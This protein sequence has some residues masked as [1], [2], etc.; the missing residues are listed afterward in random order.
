MANGKIVFSNKRGTMTMVPPP[1][2]ANPL[3]QRLRG[4]SATLRR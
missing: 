1:C 2:F 4:E 3:R